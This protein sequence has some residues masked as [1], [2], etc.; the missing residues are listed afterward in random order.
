[1][2]EVM[3]QTQL[4]TEEAALR[5]EPPAGLGLMPRRLLYG[6]PLTIVVMDDPG[7]GGACHL[8]EIR[9]FDSEKNPSDPF[10]ARYGAPAE[11]CTLLFQ[12]GPIG[13]VGVNGITN[14]ALLAIL[15][16]RLTG[17][18]SGPHQ[19]SENE[20][21]LSLLVAAKR[22]LAARTRRRVEAGTEGTSEGN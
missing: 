3:S 16:D 2:E 4:T 15:V 13:E 12:N 7:P 19:C 22:V 18:Q 10:V 14:E 9:G 17:F 5:P 20:V 11:R 6:H 21:A 1:M 8:Y